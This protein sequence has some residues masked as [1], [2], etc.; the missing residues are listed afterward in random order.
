MLK[1]KLI[2]EQEEGIIGN[3]ESEIV[4]HIHEI[5]EDYAEAVRLYDELLDEIDEFLEGFPGYE[6]CKRDERA[7][8]EK[9]FS[10]N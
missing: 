3:L 6:T 8:W 4:S 1:V 5:M 7:D 9:V 10:P 2:I